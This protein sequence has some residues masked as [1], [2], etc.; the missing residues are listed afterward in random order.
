MASQAPR[1]GDMM[2][3]L[4]AYGLLIGVSGAWLLVFG[5]L[6]RYGKVRVAEPNR[7]I[8]AF[9]LIML[10]FIVGFAVWGLVKV[11]KKLRR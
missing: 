6:Y 1:V 3:E 7:Y 11:I 10:V 8:K 2:T 4:L 9:E 5:L